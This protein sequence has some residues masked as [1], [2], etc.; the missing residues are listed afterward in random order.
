MTDNFSDSK[1]NQFETTG[2]IS[3][4]LEF[5]GLNSK[6]FSNKTCSDSET[7]TPIGVG[8]TI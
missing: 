2:K 3:D 6:S 8:K 5:K 4:Y 1:W 7:K